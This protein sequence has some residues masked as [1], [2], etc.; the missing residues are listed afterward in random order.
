M[1][2]AADSEGQRWTDGVVT[3]EQTGVI[4]LFQRNTFNFTYGFTKQQGKCNKKTTVYKDHS[5][6]KLN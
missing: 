6:Y 3:A 2:S 4:Q 5:D 1:Q